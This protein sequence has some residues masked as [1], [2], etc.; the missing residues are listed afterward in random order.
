MAKVARDV[1]AL[2]VVTLQLASTPSVAAPQE[3][4]PGA[5]ARGRILVMPRPGL[6]DA[7]LAKIVSVHGGKARK[8][9]PFG[10]HVVDLPSNASEQAVVSLLAHN[11]HLKF[12]ELDQKVTA[13]LTPNDPYFGSEWHATKI[14][15][16]AAWDSTSGAG[17]T[18]A[19]LDTGV[20]GTHPDLTAQM[21]PGWNF[22]SNNSSTSDSHGH[23]TWVSG[24]AAATGSNGVGVAAIAGKANVMPLVVADATETA[25]SS[26]ISQGIS[27]AID[28]GARVANISYQNL[29]TSSS[30]PR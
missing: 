5:Y 7:E 29:L 11:P 10:L 8:I 12:A 21:V 17:V 27:Y 24:T 9:T 3:A 18:I 16:P 15:A 14:G 26:T 1:T 22:F 6:S 2:S 13:T 23:G 20:D 19:I 25:Y 28:H 30:I 4:T